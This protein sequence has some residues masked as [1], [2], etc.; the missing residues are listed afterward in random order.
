MADTDDNQQQPEEQ[1]N[2]QNQQQ[3]AQGHQPNQT[4]IGFMSANKVDAALWGTRMFTVI[5]TILFIIPI[6]GGNSYSFYQR[7]LISN[8]ATSALRLHQRVPH[9]QLNREFF[10]MLF[11]EDS[12]H[13][14]FFSLIF[15]TSYPMTMALVPVFLFGLLHSVSYTK[16]LL[17]IMG[18]NSQQL[19]R[20][21]IAK[22]QLQQANILRFIACNEI[23][24]MPATVIMIFSGSG[25]LLMPFL[26]YRFLS[27]RYASRRNPY[28]RALFYELRVT[29]EHFSNMPQCPAFLR[30][31]VFKAIGYINRLAPA[32]TPAQ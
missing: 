21:L 26:Y 15:I 9:F 2:E 17:D 32:T 30:N 8:A 28:S 27:L 10:S 3:E 22:L 29:A 25:S 1:Q 19:L 16:K 12:A 18:P 11:M 6:F 14:L 31:L 4:I 13:Y 7:A 23:F 20:N 5:S 24:L